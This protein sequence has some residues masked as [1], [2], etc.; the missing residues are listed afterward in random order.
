LASTVFYESQTDI[1]VYHVVRRGLDGGGHGE[2]SAFDTAVELRGLVG[3]ERLLIFGGLTDPFDTARSIDEIDEMVETAGIIGLKFYPWELDA[4]SGRF[5]EFLFSDEGLA[6]PLLEHLEKRGIGAMGIHKAMGSVLRAFG[7]GDLDR[8][9]MDF[10]NLQFEVVHG[11]WAFLEDTLVLAS[12]P[13]VYINLEGTSS[14]A[15]NSPH[16]FAE[17]LGRLLTRGGGEPNAED[18]ILWGTGAT[19]AHPQPLLEVFWQ[20]Q[21]PEELQEKYGFR[22]LTDEIKRKILGGN[23]ARKRSTT[24]EALR[25]QLPNDEIAKVQAS[26]QLRAP[27]SSIPA[28]DSVTT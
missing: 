15:A 12:Q 14:L 17:I 16:R 4:K 22:P 9:V 8:A 2:W 21:M 1:A 19:A 20:F 24:A 7:V 5:R 10:P 25:S 13:N 23:F 27:W 28:L 3:P 26:G 18:R 11:G 6:Y